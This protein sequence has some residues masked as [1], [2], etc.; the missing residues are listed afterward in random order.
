MSDEIR[1]LCPKR[2]GTSASHC[3]HDTGCVLTSYPGY[4]VE[5]C[6]Y[7]GI[8][9]HRGLEPVQPTTGH[10][11]YAGSS[12]NVSVGSATSSGLPHGDKK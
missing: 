3:W 10:G 5:N 11:P 12:F 6:C 2:D 7:C 9:R 8:E 1:P 4:A